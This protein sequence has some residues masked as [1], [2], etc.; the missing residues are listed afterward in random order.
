[1]SNASLET[2][3]QVM[4]Y[5]DEHGLTETCNKYNI[6]PSTIDRYDRKLRASQ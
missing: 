5:Y 3:R 6:K 2:I 1:M 4:E